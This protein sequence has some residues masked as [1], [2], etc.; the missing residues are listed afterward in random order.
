MLFPNNKRNQGSLN[1][2]DMILKVADNFNQR[3]VISCGGFGV[4][5]KSTLENGTTVT[6]AV[7]KLS[8][9]ISSANIPPSP[10]NSHAIVIEHP[11]PL[12]PLANNHP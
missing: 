9:P 2:Q 10:S 5:Y 1:S 11:Q 8:A 7:K 12:P 3:N 6:V 4:V